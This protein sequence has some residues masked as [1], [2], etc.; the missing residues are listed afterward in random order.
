MSPIG[1]L[2]PV[3]TSSPALYLD[4]ARKGGPWRIPD[5]LHERMKAAASSLSGYHDVL[6]S[7]EGPSRAELARGLESATYKVLSWLGSYMPAEIASVLQEEVELS[8]SN[9]NLTAYGRCM[10][11]AD[12]AAYLTSAL[13]TRKL[14]L[15]PR[16]MRQ[17]AFVAEAVR[18][19]KGTT[20]FL[21]CFVYLAFQHPGI[22]ERCDREQM[23]VLA[24][25]ASSV[26]ADQVATEKFA[27]KFV[28]A[29]R[30]V[31]LSLRYRRFCPG[32][33]P[34][35]GSSTRSSLERKALPEITQALDAAVA[36]LK[37]TGKKTRKGDYTVAAQRK[38]D[39]AQR[40][41]EWLDWTAATDTWVAVHD[42]GDGDGD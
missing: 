7:G 28:M 42:E 38:I 29:L 25:H 9:E 30:S 1:A 2:R 13:V 10:K 24:W 21:S 16:Y 26:V 36:A 41:R 12:S 3:G 20:N 8:P 11:D 14:Q 19:G 27:R 23:C 40:V 18:Q 17:P 33:D 31:A 34:F 35:L 37:A 32:D 6:R 39:L 15:D 5:S 4:P 22:L